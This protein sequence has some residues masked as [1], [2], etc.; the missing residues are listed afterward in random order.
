MAG[1]DIQTKADATKAKADAAKAKADAAKEEYEAFRISERSIR[2]PWKLDELKSRMDE[3][4]WQAE[5][6][7]ECEWALE[8]AAIKA[9]KTP[10]SYHSAREESG[11][12]E[13]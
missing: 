1:E 11:D 8:L 9:G 7:F 6:I 13:Q 10:P 5:K 3:I 4:L 12:I 2:A